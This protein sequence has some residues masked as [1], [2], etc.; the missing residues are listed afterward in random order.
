MKSELQTSLA[1]LPQSIPESETVVGSGVDLET[2][3]ANVLSQ[4]TPDTDAGKATG[5]VADVDGSVRAGLGLN[6][7]FTGEVVKIDRAV[8]TKMEE[9]LT[10]SGNE[11]VTPDTAVVVE[12]KLPSLRQVLEELLV[13]LKVVRALPATSLEE[14]GAKLLLTLMEGADA[15]VSRGLLRLKRVEDVVDLDELL[16]T[17]LN[18]INLGSACGKKFGHGAADT[19][20]LCNPDSLGDIEV[21]EVGGLANKRATIGGERHD[22]VETVVDLCLAESREDLLRQL[23]AR[24][25]ILG[26]E[27]QAGRHVLV[28]DILGCLAQRGCNNWHG[29]MAVISNTVVVAMLTVVKILILMS[30][31][32]ESS[33]VGLFVLALLAGN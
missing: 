27:L 13:S 22:T 26:S 23:P 4:G 30:E 16:G 17:S 29:T 31:N 33:T 25:E 10:Q 11:D 28:I 2:L 32:R 24:F 19:S 12:E 3:L 1:T 20:R 8:D 18:H 15:E 6:L 5:D 14:K 21:I 9:V 7:G